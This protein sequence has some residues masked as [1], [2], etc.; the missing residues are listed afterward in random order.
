[1]RS[2]RE[3]CTNQPKYFLCEVLGYMTTIPILTYMPDHGLI[4]P[5]CPKD[6]LRFLYQYTETN[7]LIGTLD[8]DI[9]RMVLQ[10]SG[11]VN[12]YQSLVHHQ[13]AAK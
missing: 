4:S 1:M 10:E 12:H 7:F 6:D 3:T 13:S 8:D 9:Q 2:L 5:E 11:F